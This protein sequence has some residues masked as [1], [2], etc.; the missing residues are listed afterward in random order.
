M[1][2]SL[3][4]QTRDNGSLYAHIF[5]YPAGASPFDSPYASHAVAPLTVYSLP[6]DE[7]INLLSSDEKPKQVRFTCS[8]TNPNIC[9][10][11]PFGVFEKAETRVGREKRPGW[12]ETI[13]PQL[14]K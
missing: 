2:A 10:Y 1:N 13:S 9:S 11:M 3:P 5:I 6:Q 7:S 4:Q 12:R 14:R 8:T